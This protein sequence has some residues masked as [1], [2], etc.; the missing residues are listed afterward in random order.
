MQMRRRVQLGMVVELVGS[1]AAKVLFHNVDLTNFLTLTEQA[2]SNGNFVMALHLAAVWWYQ[3]FTRDHLLARHVTRISFSKPLS[4]I[5]AGEPVVAFVETGPWSRRLEFR[6]G[7]AQPA[8]GTDDDGAGQ[9]VPFGQLVQLG[10]VH[11]DEARGQVLDQAALGLL[12]SGQMHIASE[13]IVAD[14]HKKRLAF[15]GDY[16]VTSL[17]QRDASGAYQ[18]LADLPPA[19]QRPLRWRGSSALWNF[20]VAALAMGVGSVAMWLPSGMLPRPAWLEQAMAPKQPSSFR[21]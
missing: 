21:Y 11:V 15:V 16:E 5:P 10:A 12:M 3:G 4:K 6:P 7:P 17:L 19:L 1:Q 18:W 8:S 9:L 20:G 2:M 13:E 14:E